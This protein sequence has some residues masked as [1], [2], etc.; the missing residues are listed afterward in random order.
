MINKQGN[1]EY[2]FI[3]ENPKKIY[4]EQI[5]KDGDKSADRN[6]IFEKF[7]SSIGRY[8]QGNEKSPLGLK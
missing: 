1:G 7:Q 6:D 2:F 4:L 8:V 3:S 5:N